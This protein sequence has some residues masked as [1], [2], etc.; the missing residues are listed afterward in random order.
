MSVIT[1]PISNPALVTNA[2]NTIDNTINLD[3]LFED[4]VLVA[5]AILY[6]I[7][8]PLQFNSKGACIATTPTFTTTDNGT[9]IEIV[10]G[11]PLHIK[12]AAGSET[13]KLSLVSKL[14]FQ[15]LGAE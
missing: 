14:R 4:S 13:F 1:A 7:S 3:G 8:A 10:K 6:G 11:N 2:A 9:Q 15:G 5:I 12:G